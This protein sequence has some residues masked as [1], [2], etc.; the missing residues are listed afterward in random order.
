M[1]IHILWARGI[2]KEALLAGFWGKGAAPDPD[3]L[4]LARL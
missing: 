4:E 1:M 3:L 2:K